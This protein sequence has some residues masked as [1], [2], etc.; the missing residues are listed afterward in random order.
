MVAATA[1][2]TAAASGTKPKP[3]KQPAKKEKIFHPESRKAGQ[4]ARTQLRKSKLADAKTKRGRKNLALVD[5][6]VFFFHAIPPE[7]ESITLDQLHE[8]VRDVWL[9][10]HDPEIE[11]E[12]AARRKGRPQ[13]AREFALEQIKQQELEEY[14]TGIEVPDLTHPANVAVFR[15]WDEMEAAYIDLLRFI[16]I[17]SEKPDLLVVSRPGKHASLKQKADDSVMDTSA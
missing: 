3:K 7:A 11:Q 15:R 16:R 10:R 6:Y 2:P 17:S 12:R 13:S 4:L 1:S 5:K 14:R 9:T 8:L